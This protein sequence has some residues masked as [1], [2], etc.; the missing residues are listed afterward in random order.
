LTFGLSFELTN[1]GTVKLDD[2]GRVAFPVFSVF[3]PPEVSAKLT[4]QSLPPYPQPERVAGITAV[5]VMDFLVDSS[6]HALP[7]SFKEVWPPT[8]TRPTGQ[9]LAAYNDF[10]DSVTRWLPTA[11]FEPARIG[12]CKLT[13]LV[14]EPFTF[15]ISG[16]Q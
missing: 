5:V 7:S 2:D 8:K 15:S 14:R 11:E 6:G 16:I 4:H 9:M 10:L 13:Q 1:P 3:F 12:G